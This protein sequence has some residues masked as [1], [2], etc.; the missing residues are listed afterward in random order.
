MCD[1]MAIYAYIL[2]VAEKDEFLRL[3]MRAKEAIFASSL[4]Q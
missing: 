4:A 3:Q 2:K 1:K